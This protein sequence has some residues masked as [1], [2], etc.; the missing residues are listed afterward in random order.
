MSSCNY[1]I[2]LYQAL[3]SEILIDTN[4]LNVIVAVINGM[5]YDVQRILGMGK[6]K[7]S[8]RLLN[9]RLSFCLFCKVNQH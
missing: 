1:S 5:K 9:R 3:L 7:A 6:E 8:P 2:T 4:L